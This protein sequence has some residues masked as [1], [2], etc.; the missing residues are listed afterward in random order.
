MGRSRL[1]G[2]GGGYCPW[3]V[4]R[5]EVLIG[6][7]V[8]CPY[9]CLIFEGSSGTKVV[10]FGIDVKGLGVMRGWLVGPVGGI[11]VENC[12]LDWVLY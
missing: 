2:G 8:A 9:D 5:N 7:L 1:I 6:R 12:N 11:L 4:G 3:K 10:V